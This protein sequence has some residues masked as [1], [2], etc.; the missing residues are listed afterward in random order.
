[1][2]LHLPLLEVGLGEDVAVDPHQ[3]GFD[4]FGG[5]AGRDGQGDESHGEQPERRG[6]DCMS[7]LQSFANQYFTP[8]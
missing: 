3:D 4:G 2:Y 8:T 6:R 7:D 5:R 1:M